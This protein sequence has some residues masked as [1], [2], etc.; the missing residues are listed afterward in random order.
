M[1]VKRYK[2]RKYREH[3]VPMFPHTWDQQDGGDFLLPFV[4]T[5]K[6][7]TKTDTMKARTV[8]GRG[9]VQA[10]SPSNLAPYEDSTSPHTRTGGQVGA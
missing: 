7:S 9:Q 6:I 1:E 2:L 8:T 3:T 5:N 10:W 4:S